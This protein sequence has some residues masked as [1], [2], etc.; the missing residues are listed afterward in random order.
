MTVESDGQGGIKVVQGA[1]VGAKTKKAE[2]AA[3]FEETRQ[4][5]FIIDKA[6]EAEEIIDESISTYGAGTLIDMAKSAFPGTQEYKLKNQILPAIK[7]SIALSS[8]KQLKA[9]SPTGASGLGSLT[10]KE[11]KRLENMYGV[12]DVGG[13]KVTLKNDIKRL[14][15][16]AFDY[17]HG[18]KSEREEALANGDITKDQ[19]DQVEQMYREQILGVSAP[20]AP[21]SSIPRSE[22]IEAIR[23]KYLTPND[24]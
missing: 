3:K 2:R 4:T 5:N 16:T 1:G 20:K 24:Q 12:L 9:A 14:K 17:I 23:K 10:E 11:G 18:S 22:E 7:D 19:N 13:D 8:L 6:N 15:Q 21:A